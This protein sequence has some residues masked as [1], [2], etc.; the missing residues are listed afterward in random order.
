MIP[1]VLEFK[2]DIR[3]TARV[4]SAGWFGLNATISSDPHGRSRLTARAHLPYPQVTSTGMLSAN[5]C[6][7]AEII[8]SIAKL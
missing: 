5:A 7:Q 3:A 4:S 1:I 8:S 6:R 2:S